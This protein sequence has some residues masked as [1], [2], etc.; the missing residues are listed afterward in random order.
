MDKNILQS[1]DYN[2]LREDER[3]GKNIAYLTVWGSISF[4]TNNAESDLDIR[5]FAVESLNSILTNKTFE[6]ITDDKT[7][8]VIYG[9]RKF[10]KLCAENNPNALELLGTRPEHVLYMNAAGKKIRDNAEIFLSKL[11]YKKYVG[12]ATAQLRRL[13][14]ALAHDSYPQREKNIHIL[15]SIES[16]MTACREEYGLKNSEINFEIQDEEIL[17]SISAE[18]LPLQK[19]LT[20][21]SGLETLLRSYAKLNRRDCKKDEKHLN[22]HAM[23][24]IRL[25]LTGI[26]ILEGRGVITYREK[27]LPLLKKIRAG[28]ISFEEIFKMANEYER[29]ISSAYKNSK[30]PDVPDAAKLDKILLEIY[31]EFL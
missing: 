7:D 22:K 1:V 13:Q 16:M 10:F 17:I 28:E 26:D 29:K 21:N 5:G 23:H 15:K 4:G 18:K 2:F 20:M 31:G 30:L 19:F 24:L 14:N 11:A 12:F 25:Y 3:L 9:L 27:E 8:T 6:Q